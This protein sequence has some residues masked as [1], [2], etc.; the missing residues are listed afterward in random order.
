MGDG[1]GGE[2]KDL[3]GACVRAGRE[4]ARRTCAVRVRDADHL[5]KLLVRRVLPYGC[6]QIFQLL[7]V[8]AAA[9]VLCVEKHR[10]EGE[11]ES[12]KGGSCG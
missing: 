8:N 9:T 5:R 11:S 1:K 12:E 3:W 4:E 7:R 6:H 2:G 10:S